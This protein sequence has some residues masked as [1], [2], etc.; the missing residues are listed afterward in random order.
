VRAATEL[1]LEAKT[2][3]GRSARLEK[4]AR[5]IKAR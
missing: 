3:A 5:S 1:Y 4:I 2:P